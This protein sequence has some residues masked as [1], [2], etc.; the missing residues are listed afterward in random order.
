MGSYH[1]LLNI[2]ERGISSIPCREQAQID[3]EK[4]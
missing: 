2:Y 4:Y 3:A 1:V